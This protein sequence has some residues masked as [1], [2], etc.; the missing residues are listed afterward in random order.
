ML[1]NWLTYL[2]LLL[3]SVQLC[4]QVATFNN[5]YPQGGANWGRSIISQNDGSVVVFGTGNPY[6]NSVSLLSKKIDPQGDIIW[7]N[8]LG[9]EDEYY[10]NSLSGS[11]IPV[12]NGGYITAGTFQFFNPELESDAM[13]VRFDSFGDTLWTQRYETSDFT[14]GYSVTETTD[15]GFL[16]CGFIDFGPNVQDDAL[17]IKTDSLGNKEWSTYIGNNGTLI[18]RAI[19]AVVTENGYIVTVGKNLNPSST[20]STYQS[21]LI[22][23]DLDG[24]IVGER[25]INTGNLPRIQSS[26]DSGYFIIQG[27]DTLFN[28]TDYSI[29]RLYKL[30]E[31]LSLSW[32]ISFLKGEYF[33]ISQLE[34]L[35]NNNVLL[36]GSLF[37]N[38]QDFIGW[39]SKVDSNGNILWEYT[40]QFNPDWNNYL[41]DISTTQDG[42]II[43]TGST[44][45]IENLESAM[46]L[47]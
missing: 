20:N 19:D 22:S 15:Q 40:Y 16:L 6:P 9:Q 21:V 32:Q 30:E 38:N 42:G 28:N 33:G 41:R 37:N 8:S 29:Q 23:L 7:E 44:R 3:I 10:F 46:W 39:I 4:G 17:I 27:K 35:P 18:D 5:A 1:K 24:N 14:I 25:F 34:V 31:D 2:F 11:T 13:L 12:S 36:V 45:T 43:A 47:L 26:K